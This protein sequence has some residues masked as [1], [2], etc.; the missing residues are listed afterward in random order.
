M[1]YDTLDVVND[2]LALLGE[3]PVNDLETEHPAVP[4]A[5]RVLDNTNT[6]LQ[7]E[8]WWFN[9]EYTTLTPQVGNK[10]IIVPGDTAAADTLTRV[11]AVAVRGTYLYNTDTGSY[12]FD[13]PVSVRLHRVVPFEQLPL[14]ARAYV[15]VSAQLKF[16]TTIDADA[17]KTRELKE[18]RQRAYLLM[19]AEHIRAA[20]AN[21]LA[22]PG[23]AYI[24]NN[25]QGQS[26][27]AGRL[28]Y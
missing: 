1:S 5:V 26:P 13:R 22:R 11:P 4:G 28:K 2:M 6:L 19:N 18:E 8:R 14:S 17:L 9:T 10:R 24:L 15:A 21:M 12:E 20:R 27:F 25:M 7:A 23:V 3:L 16:Q